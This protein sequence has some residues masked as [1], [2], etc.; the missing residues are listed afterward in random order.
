MLKKAFV[1]YF[2][3]GMHLQ[4]FCLKI[5]GGVDSRSERMQ[6]LLLTFAEAFRFAVN[7]LEN[8]TSSKNDPLKCDELPTTRPSTATTERPTENTATGGAS[9]APTN[10]TLSL[11]FL[12]EAKDAAFWKHGG[13]NGKKAWVDRVPM[14]KDIA[15]KIHEELHNRSLAAGNRN[16]SFQVLVYLPFDVEQDEDKHC[17]L[18]EIGTSTK[19]FNEKGVNYFI[20]YHASSVDNRVRELWEKI[21]RDHGSD[22]ADVVL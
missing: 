9:G 15:V 17:I 4:A 20:Q 5:T 2:Y 7:T 19:G 22:I 10:T 16:A 18:Q 11:S 13:I 21:R 1:Q 12:K 8:V 6:E 14:H 3:L